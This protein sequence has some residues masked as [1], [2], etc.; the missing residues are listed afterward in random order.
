L[1]SYFLDSV[2]INLLVM[3]S[4]GGFSFDLSEDDKDMEK[5]TKLLQMRYK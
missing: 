3:P 1:C 4:F 5:I 2:G